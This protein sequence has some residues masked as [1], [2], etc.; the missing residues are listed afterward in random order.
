M[1]G[2]GH[3]L[4]EEH[5]G[6]F[7]CETSFRVVVEEPVLLRPGEAPNRQIARETLCPLWPKPLR[8]RCYLQKMRS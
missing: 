7:V 5:L 3:L 4:S 8:E 6:I 1:S 2:V